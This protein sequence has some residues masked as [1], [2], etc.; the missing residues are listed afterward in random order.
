MHSQTDPYAQILHA[1]YIFDENYS[2]QPQAKIWGAT[3][4]PLTEFL[5]STQEL[6]ELRL[7][8]SSGFEV[9]ITEEGK[10]FIQV[11]LEK[12]ERSVESLHRE[13]DFGSFLES[14]A[15]TIREN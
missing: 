7:V 3:T 2:F 5:K 8:S 6:V 12:L 1:I 9:R 4:L 13:G 11:Y 15:R 10:K 14:C